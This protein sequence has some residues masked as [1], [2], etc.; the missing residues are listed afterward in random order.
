MQ[1]GH[2]LNIQTFKTGLLNTLSHEDRQRRGGAGGRPGR[3]AG[4]VAPGKTDRT[5]PAHQAKRSCGL[6]CERTS[7]NAV[8]LSGQVFQH[9]P[10]SSHEEGV[11]GV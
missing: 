3:V 9:T 4:G 7:P 11:G 1:V 5:P 10:V 8:R 6:C 2:P